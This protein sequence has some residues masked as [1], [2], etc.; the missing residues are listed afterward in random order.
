MCRSV[1]MVAVAVTCVLIAGCSDTKGKAIPVSTPPMIARP[2]VERELDALLLNPEQVNPIMGS[3]AMTVVG[4]QATMADNSGTL[5]PPECL[6]IDGPAEATAYANSGFW[7]EREQSMNDGDKFTHYLKQAVVLFPT[8]EKAQAF[9]DASAQ[10]WQ[11]CTQYIHT[12]SQS[13][14]SVAPIGNAN[15]VLSTVSTEQNAAAPGWGCG[16]ALARRNNVIID[17]NTCSPNPADTAVKIA[18]Q[19]GSNVASRW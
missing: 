11:T 18:N 8:P 2:L 12:Q 14:W 10:Q 13:H 9:F 19:I 3:T 1:A 15:D 7:A 5:T 6:V 16:R 4:T 17:V